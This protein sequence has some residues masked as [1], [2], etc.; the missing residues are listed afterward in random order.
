VQRAQHGVAVDV[1]NRGEVAGRGEAL[2]AGGLAVGDRAANLGGDLVVKGERSVRAAVDRAYGTR[3]TSTMFGP[4]SPAIAPPRPVAG[5]LRALFDEAWARARTRRRRLLVAAL[6]AVGVVTAGALVAQRAG[7]PAPVA[8]PV[9]PLALAQAPGIG[10]A[11]PAAPNSIACD[12]V[13]IAVWP[14]EAPARLVATIGGHSV[15]LTDMHIARCAPRRSCESF[16]NGYLQP[17]GLLHGALKVTPDAGRYRWYG[18]HPVTGTLRL[19]ATYRD[20]T[21]ATTTRRVELGPG[22]G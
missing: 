20:G 5:R 9:A 14:R 15:A 16:F 22:F 3:Q 18:R 6:V 17:A 8:P 2:A 4:S 21:Q 11:C 13:G 12:R 7:A 19:D 1:E 10:V